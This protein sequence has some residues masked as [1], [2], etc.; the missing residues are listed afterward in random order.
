[1]KTDA[2]LQADVQD[3]LLWETRVEEAGEIAVFAHDGTVT[4]R[5]TVG[6]LGAKHHAT[7]AAKR[8]AG[9]R[10][11]DNQLDVRLLI[12]HRRDDADLRGAALRALSWN[13]LI[14]DGVDVTVMDGVVTLTGVVEFRHQRDAAAEAVRNLRGVTAIH[15]E[16]RVKSPILAGDVTA[17]IEKAFERNA[18]IEADA[19]RV[20]A[21]DGT[22]TLTGNVASWAEHDA[23]LDAAWAAPGVTEVKDQLELSY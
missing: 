9:V 3:E 22:V 23:A 1:M 10:R 14:P 12:E 20:E 5:G 19:L 13:V 11:V 18:H 21:I 6:S 7:N 2:E 17:R 4:L 15:D 8:V 16:I